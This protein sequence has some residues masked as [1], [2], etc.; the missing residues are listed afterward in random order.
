[1][2]EASPLGSTRILSLPVTEH[3]TLSAALS[4]AEER[5]ALYPIHRVDAQAGS[6]S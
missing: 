3:Q 1:M 6:P 2:D 5:R 4:S